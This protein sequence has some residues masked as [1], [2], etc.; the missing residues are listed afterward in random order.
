MS[1]DPFWGNLFRRRFNREHELY[2]ILKAVP[3]FQDLNRR[4]FKKIHGILHFRDFSAGEAVV[5]EGDAGVGMYIVMSGGVEIV[6]SGEDGATNRLATFGPGDFFGDQVLVD[7]SPRTA[8]AIATEATKAV[9]FFR[10]DLLELIERNPRLGLKIVMRL[11]QTISIRL[12][13]TNRLLKESRDRV[14]EIEN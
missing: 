5:R 11:S 13:Q 2:E 14:K 3:I 4:D 1:D 10:P 12:R 6:Q 8:S 9:G 7:E